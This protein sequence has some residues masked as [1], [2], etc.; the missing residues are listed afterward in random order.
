MKSHGP[1][2]PGLTLTKTAIASS[3]MVRRLLWR[4]QI[5]SFSRFNAPTAIN[6][7]HGF[8]PQRHGADREVLWMQARMVNGH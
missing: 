6:M 2:H 7:E 5:A 3:G 4:M 8:Y 1:S